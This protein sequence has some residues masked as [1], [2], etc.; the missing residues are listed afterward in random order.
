M[1]IF[2]NIIDIMHTMIDFYS[3]AE[4]LFSYVIHITLFNANYSFVLTSS[5]SHIKPNA[6]SASSL[7]YST[8]LP[9]ILNLCG[10]FE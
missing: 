9:L 6:P 7:F 10:V 3:R 5:A 2:P 1:V 4:F 8:C